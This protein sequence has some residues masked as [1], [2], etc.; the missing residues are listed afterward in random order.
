M[1]AVVYCVDAT[2]RW[3]A[4]GAIRLQTICLLALFAHPRAITP[5]PERN[6][7]GCHLPL[8]FSP[9]APR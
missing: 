8:S 1:A 6:I 4:P 2:E 3:M 5:L 7:D 9:I